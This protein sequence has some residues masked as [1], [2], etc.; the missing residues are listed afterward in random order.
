MTCSPL[1]AS[2]LGLIAVLAG[3]HPPRPPSPPSSR[4]DPVV[5]EGYIEAGSGVRLFYRLVGTGGDTVIVLHG[6]PGFNMEYFA[7]DLE[8]LAA[9]HT[10]LFYDQRG[11]GRS[12]LVSDSASLDGKRFAEDLEAV[13]RHFGLARVTLLG[14][15]W[16]AGVIALYAVQHPDRI[17]R[18]LV[19]GGIPLR[20]KDLVAVFEDLAARRDSTTRAEMQRWSEARVADPGDAA[21]CHAYYVLWFVPFFGDTSAAGRSKGD[22]CAGTPESRR[23]KI[24]SV[25]RFV[26]TSLGDWDWRATLRRVTAPTLVIHGTEDV[27]PVAGGREWA[28]VV[29]QARLLLLEGIGHFP[30]LEAP[31]RFFA[32]V[33]TF[34]RGSWPTEAQ[35]VVPQ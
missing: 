5:Q 28:A 18:L 2:S 30:Y 29:P 21:A 6:G 9:T 11:A 26:A 15:S 27:L 10:L 24:V 19:V 25:D 22:F 20:Q 1:A 4:S 12:T 33:D 7:K 16:G 32:A 13:R 8:P 3:C 23:N 34:L 31:E 14:H 35:A 17:G